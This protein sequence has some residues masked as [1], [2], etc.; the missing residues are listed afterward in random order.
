MNQSN[1]ENQDKVED[2]R[3]DLGTGSEGTGS[4]LGG[5]TGTPSSDLE[6]APP[7][8]DQ[9]EGGVVSGG[10]MADSADEERLGEDT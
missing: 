10:G 7:S 2:D 8:Q 1:A 3:A 9:D 5:A 4:G 6:E